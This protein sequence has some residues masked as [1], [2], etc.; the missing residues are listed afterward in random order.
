MCLERGACL[1]CMLNVVHHAI[2]QG[3]RLLLQ[4]VRL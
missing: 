2:R 3:S 4:C 1:F